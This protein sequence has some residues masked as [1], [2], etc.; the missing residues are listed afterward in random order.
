MVFD[1]PKHK[2]GDFL[3]KYNGDK[4]KAYRAIEDELIKHID[5][6]EIYTT[7]EWTRITVNG[8][9][10]DATW[11]TINGEVL[12]VDASRRDVL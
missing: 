2:L 4:E 11:R 12:L 6:T 3:S 1:D 9:E 5:K 7:T 10:F 8:E